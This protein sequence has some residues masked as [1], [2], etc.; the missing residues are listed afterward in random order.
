MKIR[1]RVRH[2]AVIP[3]ASMA[4]IAML[5]LIFFLSTTIFKPR[6]ALSVKLPG[7]YTGDRYRREDAIRIWVGADG[8]VSFNDAV[9]RLDRVGATLARK[10]AG[11]P[12]IAVALEADSRV[13]YSTV[14]E[15]IGQ[16]ELARAPR[17][18]FA[19]E[20]GLRPR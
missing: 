4:D 7:S 12:A 5:L 6:E 3:T 10:M 8:T 15:L 14:A 18:T 2:Q 16:I 11:N 17:V 13:P 20:G 1:R 9:V 19:T